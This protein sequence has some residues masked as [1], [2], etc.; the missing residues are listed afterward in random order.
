VCHRALASR[1]KG[2]HLAS[3]GQVT[4]REL[5]LPHLPGS[6]QKTREHHSWHTQRSA[7]REASQATPRH[8]FVGAT[9]SG[10]ID[11]QGVSTAKRWVE[12]KWA[13][14]CAM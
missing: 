13:G 4:S 7:E 6:P 12:A 11:Q 8:G 2:A 9:C 3:Q 10:R 14:C 1:K 5:P